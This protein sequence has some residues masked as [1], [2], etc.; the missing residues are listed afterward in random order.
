MKWRKL[1]V[2][3]KVKVGDRFVKPGQVPNLASEGIGLGHPYLD[4]WYDDPLFFRQW[5]AWRKDR[6][7]ADVANPN[8]D[9]GDGDDDIVAQLQQ[10]IDAQPPM[11]FVNLAA[12]NA[13]RFNDPVA[14]PWEV[15]EPKPRARL[16]GN[17]FL[18]RPLPLP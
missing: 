1:G 4:R 18:A 6:L 16:P 11:R 8:A 17:P 15:N 14:V 2:G 3:E 9:I 13:V 7:D 12:R 10:V 5:R